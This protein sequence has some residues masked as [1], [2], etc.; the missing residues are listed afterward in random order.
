MQRVVYRAVPDTL[1]IPYIDS[2]LAY[3][4]KNL[5]ELQAFRIQE[6]EEFYFFQTAGG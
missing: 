4:S 2:I 5:H 6:I 3:G 1:E